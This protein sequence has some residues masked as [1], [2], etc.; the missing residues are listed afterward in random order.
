MADSNYSLTKKRN[1]MKVQSI[2]TVLTFIYIVVV[3]ITL[4][5]FG[6]MG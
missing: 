5:I 6:I 1:R 4:I 3:V 2:F